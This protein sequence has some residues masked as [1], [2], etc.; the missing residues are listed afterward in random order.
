[1]HC[2]SF[3]SLLFTGDDQFMKGKK[4][5]IVGRS[6]IV[7]APAAALFLWHHATV[8]VCHSRTV[9]LRHECQQADILVVAI[10]QARMI[11][12]KLKN[13]LLLAKQV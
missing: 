12:G 9:D 7:G 1:M 2:S 4:V 5:V 8:V 3:V 6:K 11:K 10:G 13:I